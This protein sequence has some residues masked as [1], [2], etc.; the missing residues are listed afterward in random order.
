MS[1]NEF[2]NKDV[3]MD[4]DVNMLGLADIAILNAILYLGKK[5]IPLSY[6]LEI[7]KHIEVIKSTCWSII[8]KTVDEEGDVKISLGKQLQREVNN[9]IALANGEFKIN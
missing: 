8:T 3:K 7:H 2:Q 5:E 4:N 6:M 1:K 9:F